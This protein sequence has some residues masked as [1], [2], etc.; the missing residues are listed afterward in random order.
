[1]K[2]K[3]VNISKIKPNPSNPRTI[4]KEKLDKLKKSIK[5]FQ[6]MMELRPI[7]IDENDTILGGNMRWK[8]CKELG[9]EEVHVVKESGLTEKEKKKFI[10][11]DNKAFGEWDWE[12]LRTDWTEDQLTEGG[13]DDWEIITTFGM[14]DRETNRSKHLLGE[15]FEMK[16]VDPNEAVKENIIFL[17]ELMIEFEDEEVKKAI[18]N[19]RLSDSKDSFAEELKKIIKQYGQNRL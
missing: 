4:S 16:E 6:K 11:L 2:T 5:E 19:L 9:I 13:M 1:M 3:K 17:N 18:T 12:T 7:V 15:E 10:L 8:A 14:T